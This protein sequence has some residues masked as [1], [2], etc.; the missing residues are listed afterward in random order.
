MSNEQKHVK[1]DPFLKFVIEFHNN[2]LS[3]NR[4]LATKIIPNKKLF[5][6]L[7]IAKIEEA[8]LI[9]HVAEWEIFL[10][11][12]LAYCVS[13]DATELSKF[14]HLQ[15]P[16]KL[17]FDNAVA[18]LNGLSYLSIQDSKNLKS[19][20]R[21]IL[22]KEHNPFDQFQPIC[23]NKIDEVYS[24]RNYAAHKSTKAK[25]SLL[26]MY[27]DRYNIN[28]FIEPG[29]F[30]STVIEDDE[31]G[32]LPRSNFYYGSFMT[33]ATLIWRFLNKE[34]YDFVWEDDMSKEGWLKGM[35]KMSLVFEQ[36]TREFKI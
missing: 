34:S 9:R 11:N 22:V 14:M 7:E 32:N 24:L 27:K 8:F 20:A 30:L 15:L 33:M 18:I 35:A 36:L 26:K 2:S 6:E 31:V 21:K 4:I 13:L 16:K 5:N 3:L 17:G 19:I 28:E 29:I 10:Q 25:R 1:F 23:M 12:M